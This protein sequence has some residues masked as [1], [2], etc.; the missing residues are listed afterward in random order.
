MATKNV[1]EKDT[2]IVRIPRTRKDEED[3]HVGLN[4]KDYVIKRGVDVE[5]P[6]AVAE[7]LE[8][9]DEMMERVFANQN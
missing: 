1:K 9:R 3:V 5:V 8:H 2:V 6:L 7:I 4:F